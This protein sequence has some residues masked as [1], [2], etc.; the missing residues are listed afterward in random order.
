M[1][2][3]KVELSFDLELLTIIS[4]T[5]DEKKDIIWLLFIALFGR[6]LEPASWMR[7]L[8]SSVYF[9]TFIFFFFENVSFPILPSLLF[10]GKFFFP[11]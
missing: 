10:G 3:H 1:A 4:T 11:I 9:S 5:D 7:C 2:K 6:G 8:I